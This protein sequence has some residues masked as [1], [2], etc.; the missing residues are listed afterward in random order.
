MSTVEIREGK[1]LEMRL[2]SPMSA[3]D[4]D[5][6]LNQTKGIVRDLRSSLVGCTDLREARILSPD[7]VSKLTEMMRFDNPRIVR[8]AI[9]V[10]EGAVFS[11]QIE[12]MVREAGSPLRRSF[13]ETGEACTWLASV[14]T[15]PEQ[16]RLRAFID[17]GGAGPKHPIF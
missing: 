6:F 7:A 16:R 9:L 14:L 8:N 5:E 10:G 12:R 4:V 11:M 3:A 17:E 13:R 1:L 2:V 15:R